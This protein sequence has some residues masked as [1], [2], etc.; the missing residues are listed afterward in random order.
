MKHLNFLRLKRPILF[1]ELKRPILFQVVKGSE[2]CEVLHG[3]P[4]VQRYLV[5]CRDF[6]TF[7]VK[8]IYNCLKAT[9]LRAEFP[10]NEQDRI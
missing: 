4:E 6:S 5:S 1:E 2:I 10:W 9:I 3:C 8:K 7:E